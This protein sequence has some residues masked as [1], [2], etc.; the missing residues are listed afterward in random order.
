MSVCQ[1]IRQRINYFYVNEAI[2]MSEHRA[3]TH[4]FQLA[5]VS[6]AAHFVLFTYYTFSD[7]GIRGPLNVGVTGCSPVITPLH[8][9]LPW[10]LWTRARPMYRHTDMYWP[11]WRYCR[12]IVSAKFRPYISAIF[13]HKSVALLLCMERSETQIA[14][15]SL[16]LIG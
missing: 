5:M 15:S 13:A 14:T 8:P 3:P 10:G 16:T 9:P 2:Q 11:I 1:T 12:C 4:W 7:V 6:Y